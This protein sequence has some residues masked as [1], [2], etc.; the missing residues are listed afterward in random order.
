MK[1]IYSCLAAVTFVFS[2]SAAKY[3]YNFTLTNLAD[4]LTAIAEQHPEIRLNFIYNEIDNYTTSATIDTDNP[5]EALRQA[6]GSNPVSIVTDGNHYYI[7]ARQHGKFEFSGKVVGTDNEPVAGASVMVL[8]PR[9]STVITYGIADAAG[10][11]SIP[12][13]IKNVLVKFTCTGYRIK[14]VDKPRFSMGTVRMEALPVLLST[15]SV[16]A[17][18]TV[19]YADKAVYVPS[20]RQKNAAQDAAD[21]LRRM[22]IPQ[23][24]VNPCDNSVKDVFGNSLPVYINYHEAD[25]DELSGMKITDVRRVEFI[26]F[27]TDP[28]FKGERHVVNFIV[29]EYE[30]GG[31]TKASE[32][33]TSING[34]FNKTD[35]FSRFTYKKLTYDIYAG[36]DNQNFHH[37]GA[38]AWATYVLMND[39]APTTV[40]RTESVQESDTRTN[41]FPITLRASYSTPRFTA[42]NALSFTHYS[43]PRDYKSGELKV[44]IH[45]HDRYTYARSVP[46]RNNTVSYHGNFGSMIGSGAS[47]DI[48]PS[49]KHTH[50]DNTQA[51]ASTLIPAA[52]CNLITE[53]VYNWDVR[54]SGR[55]ALG[56]KHA[57]SLFI[58]GGQNI[59]RLRYRGTDNL[60]GAYRNSYMAADFRYRFR[61]EKY[62]FTSFA[63]LGFDHNSM[64][65]ISTGDVFPRTG[66]NVSVS[67]NKKSTLSAS[68]YY[69]TTTPDI[70][71]KANDIIQDNEY[72][73]LTANP[74][75]KNWRNLTSNIAY[76]HYCNNSLSLAIFAGY[77]HDFNRVAILYR[78]FDDGKALLR[79]F[80]N[81]GAYKHCFLGASVNYKLFHNSL[82]LYANLTQNVYDIT[83]T[84]RHTYCPFRIQLQGIYYWKAF[85]VLA[86]YGN[87]QRTL[88]ENSNYI[89]RG[90]NFHMFSVGWANGTWS[91]SVAA[92]NIFNRG[93][94]ADTWEM[95]SPLY[96]EHKQYYNPSAHASLT[97]SVAYTIGY[98]KQI[99]HGDEATGQG[100]APSAIIR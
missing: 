5:Y 67:F 79:D 94:R 91:V 49:F 33:F 83:G 43:S 85:N 66:L 80:V 17:D 30:Y 61:S 52:V 9:D 86:S 2:L 88:T 75:L 42:R 13:D 64:N 41:Q 73:Y 35:V 38:D 19:L 68:L 71:M 63:G 24:I 27:P 99:R 20:S 15:V 81:D 69:Q 98:G 31:Y 34:T 93:W 92:K 18:N 44:N 10:R 21:L 4:A 59:N 12:C 100:S 54:A 82:Q 57:L 36:S 25:P 48:T 60:N 16:E 28:R 47:F 74:N 76:N 11:F 53:N 22:A 39:G 62:S 3:V 14:Y 95:H 37:G 70:S 50:R 26:E 40:R 84:Y 8:A 90:R 23:L 87:P 7:E 78:P 32:S 29:R 72:M 77:E 45:P 97:L 58:A 51:Y 46:H 89:I 55:L 65:G 6:T 96:C 1:R 56:Q